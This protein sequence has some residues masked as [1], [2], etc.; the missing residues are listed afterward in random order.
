MCRDGNGDTA[1]C[2]CYPGYYGSPS[3]SGCWPE[4]VT[5]ADCARNKACVNNRCVD[6][7]PGACG[8]QAQCQVINH[9]P[10]CSCPE[11][12]VGDPFTECRDVPP[13]KY[14]IMLFQYQTM[15]VNLINKHMSLFLLK[16]F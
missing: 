12:L 3:G 13:C 4:C 1:I 14:L 7:C 8:Y 6:P 9:S 10:V 2:E 5:S 16:E 15:Y 11:P